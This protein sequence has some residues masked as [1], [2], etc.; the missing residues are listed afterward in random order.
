MCRIVEGY[1]KNAVFYLAPPMLQNSVTIFCTTFDDVVLH[2]FF[3][4]YADLKRRTNAKTG[5]KQISITISHSAY[6]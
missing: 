5:K 1:P 2:C 4:Y 3:H 6:A